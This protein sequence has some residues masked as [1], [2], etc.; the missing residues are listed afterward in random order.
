MINLLHGIIQP[1]NGNPL[2]CRPST[3]VSTHTQMILHTPDIADGLFY[4]FM[5]SSVLFEQSTSRIRL[6]CTITASC[7]CR[8]TV[9]TV[10]IFSSRARERDFI[11]LALHTCSVSACHPHTVHFNFSS[12][13]LCSLL[14]PM[15]IQFSNHCVCVSKYRSV[16]VLSDFMLCD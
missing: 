1:Y 5:C 15:H 12:A 11:S 9:Y 7:Y 14:M 13:R 6:M 8:H 16:F 4:S 2:T 3:L 10:C